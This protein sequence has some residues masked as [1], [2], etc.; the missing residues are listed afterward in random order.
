MCMANALLGNSIG[1]TALEITVTGPT[2]LFHCDAVVAVTG[3]NFVGILEDRTILPNWTP[4]RIAAGSVVQIQQSPAKSDGNSAARGGKIGYLAIRGGFDVPEYLGSSSTFPTGNFGGLTGAFLTTGDFLPIAT[5]LNAAHDAGEQNGLAFRWPMGKRL[6]EGLIPDYCTTEWTIGA[7]IGPHASLDFLQQET[8]TT[9]WRASYTVHHATNR[10]GA[11]LIGPVPKWTRLDGGSAGLHP[12]NL[13]DYAYAPGAVNFSGNTPIVLMLDGPSLGGFVCPITVATSELWKVAQASPGERLRFKQVDFD[14][15]RNSLLS[16]KSAWEAVRSYDTERLDRLLSNWS[17][18]W[19]INSRSAD[20]DAVLA[21]LDPAKGDEAQ[22]KV[23]Y[24]MSGDEHVLV[25]YG[26]IE[27]NLAY[28]FRVHM[29]M[30]EL[31]TKSFIN[32]LCPG[33]RSVLIRYNPDKIHVRDLMKILIDVE[34]GTL[35]SVDDVVVPSRKL[36]L[37]LA[38]EDKWTVEAQ[39]RYLRSIRPDAPYMP[40]NVEFVRRINGLETVEQVKQIMNEAQYLVMGLGDVYLGAP[41]AVPVDPRHRMVTSKYNPARTYTPEGAVGIGGAYMCIYGMDSP[42]GYQLTG[43]TI[44]IWDSY[45][46]VPERCRGSQKEIPWL[47]R[48][49]DRVTFFAVSD[50]ELEH[51]RSE[52]LKGNYQI[53]ITHESFSYKYYKQFLEHSAESI[54][55]FEKKRAAAYNEERSKWIQEGEGESAAAAEHA[56][57]NGEGNEE[58][59]SRGLDALPAGQVYLKAGMSANVWSVDVREGESISKGQPLFTLESMKVEITIEAPSS[60]H[61]EQINVKKGDVVTP[62]SAL[63]ILVSSAENVITQG[64]I[65]YVRALYRS[66]IHST[67]QVIENFMGKATKLKNVFTSLAT[68]A[69]IS[70]QLEALESKLRSN[71]SMPLFG[72]PFVVGCNVDVSGFET[73]PDRPGRPYLPESSAPLVQCVQEAGA[74]LI[75]KTTEEQFNLGYTHCETG[76]DRLQNPKY[77]A[78]ICGGHGS[79]AVAVSELAASFAIV[80]DRVG[81]STNAPAFT[82]VVGMKVTQGLLPVSDNLV[83]CASIFAQDANDV[84]KILEVCLKSRTKLKNAL[85]PVPKWKKPEGLYQQVRIGTLSSQRLDSGSELVSKDVLAYQSG[86]RLLNIHENVLKEVDISPFEI[87]A[88]LCQEFPILFLKLGELQDAVRS[89]PNGL[90]PSVLERIRPL[91]NMSF[92]STGAAVSKLEECERAAQRTIWS[93][94]DVVALPVVTTPSNWEELKT[95][96]RKGTS[97]LKHFAQLVTAMDLCSL[98]LPISSEQED[99]GPGGVLLV[100]PMMREEVLIR[101]GTKWNTK[102]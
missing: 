41:C 99:S 96:I 1:A 16:M 43:R 102:T 98:T 100:A 94:V 64:D 15:A 34:N 85:R 75:G 58:A 78:T 19:I 70:T 30:E 28:R 77:P 46:K 60:G 49:F 13:H 12:S 55:D 84:S 5:D 29:L 32:E 21:S 3:G 11:R 47:L 45:G 95:D 93:D 6:P 59:E 51:I 69:Q 40:S 80:V 52:Y 27:L 31:R 72:I 86:L 20:M 26:D 54:K 35:G 82:S 53:K 33:V 92:S 90:L 81:N 48:F 91:E 63:C 37:P 73:Y 89:P 10:L 36:E 62:E 22:I 4:V 50:E 14:Q 101:V 79:A 8:L 83:D 2:L 18:H 65:S 56:K 61:V 17:P 74:V 23:E 68:D 67:R 87:A 71:C 25:E 66:E 88:S 97:S 7:L 24:R 39:G 76:G 44:P 42:G 9:I 38:F 57:G